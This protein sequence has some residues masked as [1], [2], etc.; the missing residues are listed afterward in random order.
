[1]KFRLTITC[2]KVTSAAQTHKQV[3][4][5]STGRPTAVA[6]T[7]EKLLFFLQN[8]DFFFPQSKALHL[9]KKSLKSA[10]VYT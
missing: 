7:S 3:D 8:L 2:H 1:M 4:L 5:T 6:L 10:D 9:K